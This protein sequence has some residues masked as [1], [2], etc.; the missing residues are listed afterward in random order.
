MNL[1]GM[2]LK[3]LCFDRRGK[4]VVVLVNN[5]VFFLII[6]SGKAD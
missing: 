6:I 4:L 3:K 2:T 5:H 1:V